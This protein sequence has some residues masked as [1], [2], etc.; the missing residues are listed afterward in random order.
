MRWYY[1][2]KCLKYFKYITFKFWKTTDSISKRK[3]TKDDR[4]PIIGLQIYYV[5][6][7]IKLC[8]CNYLIYCYNYLCIHFI[9]E[10]TM[11][12]N[13]RNIYVVIKKS[14]IFFHYNRKKNKL[15]NLFSAF[16]FNRNGKFLLWNRLYI[17]GTYA[18]AI[19]LTKKSK[20]SVTI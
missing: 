11:F 3:S 12:L 15:C 7:V 6:V 17:F 5:L 13:A 20:T 10:A 19:C 16:A 2:L 9:P 18:A 1:L 14:N 8:A 4:Q